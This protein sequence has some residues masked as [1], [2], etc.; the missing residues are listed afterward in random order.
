MGPPSSEH[1]FLLYLLWSDFSLFDFLVE[2]PWIS[3]VFACNR[4]AADDK[5][6]DEESKGRNVSHRTVSEEEQVVEQ[7]LET[8]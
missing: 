5:G 7:S 6:N 8:E 1:E 3:G 4:A 2:V